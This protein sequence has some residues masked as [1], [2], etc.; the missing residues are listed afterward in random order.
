MKKLQIFSAFVLLLSLALSS[1]ELIGGIF[2]AGVGFGVIMVLAVI[3]LIVFIIAKVA[4]G[5]GK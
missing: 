3:G 5:G 4:G 2:K 1:C